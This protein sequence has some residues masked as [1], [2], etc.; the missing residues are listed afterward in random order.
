MLAPLERA[1]CT[2]DKSPFLTHSIRLSFYKNKNTIC[3]KYI[4]NDLTLKTK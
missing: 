1:F 4:M 3:V 2:P